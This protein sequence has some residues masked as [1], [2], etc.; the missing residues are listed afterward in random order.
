MEP[1]G[2]AVSVVGIV[3]LISRVQDALRISDGRA[4]DKQVARSLET[5][6]QKLQIWQK[7]WLDNSI[8]T[9][10]STALWGTQGLTEVQKLLQT[11]SNTLQEIDVAHRDRY[12]IKALQFTRHDSF[13]TKPQ[14]PWKRALQ[15]ILEKKRPAGF[16]RQLTMVELATEMSSLID[17][18]WTYSEVVF[19]SLHG[20]LA[21]KAV[22]PL[23]GHSVSNFLEDAIRMRTASIALYRACSKSAR[24]CS[25]EVDLS[26]AGSTEFSSSL[27]YHL[28]TQSSDSSAEIRDMTIESVMRPDL[29]VTEDS[30]IKEYENPD[31]TIFATR[32]ASETGINIRSKTARARLHFRVAKLPAN[33]TLMPETQTLAQILYK[34]QVSSTTSSAQTLPFSARIDLAFK[35]VECALFLLGTPWLASLNSKRLQRINMKD[36]RQ[37]YVLEVQTLDLEELS[38]EDPEALAEPSQLFRIGVL[39]VEIAL[40]NPEHSVPTGTQELDLRTSKMLTLVQQSMGPQYCKATAFC[41]RDRRSTSYFGLPEKYRYPEKTGWKSYLLE[42]LED[43]HAQV[44]LRSAVFCCK[45]NSQLTSSRLQELKQKVKTQSDIE[46]SSFE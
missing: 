26:G 29:P 12:R 30:K 17:E 31:L 32:S 34:G 4:G 35:L 44:F 6:Q 3:R 15:K 38:F 45:I 9:T 46:Q 21:T 14:S 24:N 22:D 11:I 5:S 27:F 42:L 2:I 41:L 20:E 8:D 23:S 25:L 40:S 13:A 39:L 19:N 43:Y 36:G 1:F 28:S 7:T 18:L 33:I 16:V 10:T 37:P